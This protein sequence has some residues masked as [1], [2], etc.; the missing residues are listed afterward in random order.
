MKKIFLVILPVLTLAT[1][2]SL[3][4]IKNHDFSNTKN[5]P[6]IIGVVTSKF[7]DCEGGEEMDEDGNIV[8]ITEISCD[9]GSLITVS[10]REKESVTSTKETF[11]TA[12]GYVPED[13][14]YSI[15]VTH[16]NVGDSVVVKYQIDENDYKTLGCEGC[17]V[18]LADHIEILSE[19][20]DDQLE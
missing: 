12:T 16:I 10:Y 17:T 20:G 3:I 8:P 11:V 14:A 4:V 5:L 7:T 19:Q 1:I 15:D 13:M 9:G 2:I 18:R 6:S